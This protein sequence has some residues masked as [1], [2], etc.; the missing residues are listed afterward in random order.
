[1]RHPGQ[2]L[3]C[4]NI[5][6]YVWSYE[7]DVQ[8]TLVDVYISYLRNKLILPGMKDPIQTVRGLDIVWIAMMLRRLRF[9][10]SF[11]YLLAAVGLVLLVGGGSYLLMRYYLQETTDLALE[12]KMAQQYQSMG[13]LCLRNCNGRK[14]P[15]WRIM[16]ASL[17]VH[18]LSLQRCHHQRVATLMRKKVRRANMPNHQR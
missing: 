6:D 12:Y 3:T 16:H 11:L 18:R 14:E 17:A 2:T 4:Q 13:W 8:L 10:L 5:L 1:M 15:G 7:A 9:Q